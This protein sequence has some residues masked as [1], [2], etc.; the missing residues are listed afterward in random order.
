MRSRNEMNDLFLFLRYIKKTANIPK[1]PPNEEKP[2]RHHF[3]ISTGLEKKVL[4]F[5][6][7]NH[8]LPPISAP[9]NAHKNASTT[10][11][12]S[13]LSSFALIAERMRRVIKE[14]RR[15]TPYV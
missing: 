9:I 7:T 2:P 12:G 6:K 8:N 13:K 5:S 10:I 15:A 3:R 4:K 11:E 1:M 14:M